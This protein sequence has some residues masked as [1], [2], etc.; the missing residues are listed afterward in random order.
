MKVLEAAKLIERQKDA[1]FRRCRLSASPLREA[2]DWISY[3]KEFWENQLDFLADYL[4]EMNRG[5]INT[6]ETGAKPDRHA[7]LDPE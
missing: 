1:Q 2:A 5:K 4:N 3:Y 7:K 6:G